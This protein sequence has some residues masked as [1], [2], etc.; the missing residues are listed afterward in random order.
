MIGAG[1]EGKIYVLNRDQL[2]TGNNHF[3]ANG[4][5]D[6]VLQ[7]D[8][9]RLNFH[10]VFSTPAY[11]NGS[12]FIAASGD[13]LKN[14]PLAN[15]LLSATTIADTARTFSFPGATPSISANGTGS[16]IV[17]AIR[18]ANPAVLVACD[19]ATMTEIYTSTN[20]GTRDRL[21]NGV[22]FAVPTVADGKVFVGNSN[23]VSVFGL[24]GAT[25]A[26]TTNAILVFDAASYSIAETNS[27]VVIGVT[28]LGSTSG[29]VVA[30]F[31]TVGG[32]TAVAGVNY[33]S[34]SGTMN[35]GDGAGGTWY[36]TVPILNDNVAAGNR[37]VNLTI[38]LQSGN[39]VLGSPATAV[40]NILDTQAASS[41]PTAIWRAA[42]F[43][44]FSNTPA[45]SGDSADPDNDKI[46]NLLEYATGTDP[47]V[48]NFNP[49]AGSLAAGKFQLRFPRNTFATDIALVVQ[50]SSALPAWNN[51]MTWTNGG[52][53]TN[54]AGMTVSESGVSGL[55]PDTFVNVT[56][57]SLTNA[58]ATGAGP[59]F[60]RLQIHR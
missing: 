38:T 22:K 36:F 45:V 28:R 14:I 49:L 11:F 59:K 26:P 55:I 15:G 30:T 13:N 23:S 5:S 10:G 48:F 34:S 44:I 27:P 39:A 1:K 9:S 37:T 17:W 41:S 2:T 8:A 35:F 29:A 51:L 6:A 60:Y 56:L 47:E 33:S 24:L 46:P 54:L 40:L 7:T 19:A 58:P 31:Q 57:N 20:M 4:S 52:W 32:G 3:N 50:T 42:H 43:G 16:G 53:Q 18:R 12:V 21:A 25:N